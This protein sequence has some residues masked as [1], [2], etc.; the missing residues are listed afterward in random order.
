MGYHTISVSRMSPYLGAEIGNIDLSKPLSNHAAQ[1]VHDALIENNVIFF[2]DQDID[3]P[4]LKEFGRRFGTL[5]IHSGMTGLPDHPEVTRI[6]AD[7][8]SERVNG[9]EWHTDLS[10]DPIP[11]LG[12]ILHLHTVPELG[13]DT[14]FASMY[15]AYEELSDRLKAFLSG[16]TATHDGYLAFGYRYPSRQYNR[17]VHPVIAS[18]PV[19]GRKLLYVN[20]GFTSRIN[21]LP[22]DESRELLQVLFRHCEKADFQIRFRWRKNSIAFWD[23]RC[24]QHL[25]IWDYYPHTR[26]GYRVQIDADQPVSA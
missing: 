5:H 22:I 19:T 1:E 15:A 12:S 7:E 18:H 14:I 25:A 17:T 9:E 4:S 2:R 6:H 3:I 11:P 23:N 8:N 20:R 21:E 16:L 10:C 13:G 26:S 24:T